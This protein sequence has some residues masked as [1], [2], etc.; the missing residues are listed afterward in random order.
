M[1]ARSLE[2]LFARVQS[3]ATKLEEFSDDIAHEVKNSLFSIG[4]SLD[5]A[6][7]TSGRE[8]AIQKAKKTITEL[9]SLVDSLLFFARSEDI[10]LE[11]TNIK[12][13]LTDHLDLS[14]P[15]IHLDLDAKVSL[16][17]QGELFTTAVRNILHNAQK[18]TPS[19]G[20]IDII[21]S[22]NAL[23]IRDTG[24][25]LGKGEL[26]KIFDRLWK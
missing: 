6:L 25:G 19:D 23:E 20:R 14:D 4:S 16:P 9:S 5:V 10:T 8:E 13:L 1:L 15:R 18:F 12:N 3:E 17:V 7:H 21:L 11:K 2:S 22:K 26:S 24:K